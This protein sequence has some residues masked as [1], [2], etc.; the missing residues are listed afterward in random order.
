MH[1]R[2]KPTRLIEIDRWM[3][4]DTCKENNIFCQFKTTVEEYLKEHQSHGPSDLPVFYKCKIIIEEEADDALLLAAKIEK[5]NKRKQ[6]DKCNNCNIRKKSCTERFLPYS[7][8][9]CMA[10]VKKV[11]FLGKLF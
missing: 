2:T 6:K 4:C 7:E 5:K 9:S 8:R 3:P 11:A 10:K 1:I